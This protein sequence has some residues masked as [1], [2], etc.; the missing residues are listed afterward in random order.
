[1]SLIESSGP[2]NAAIPANCDGDGSK[3]NFLSFGMQK[4]D[5]KALIKRTQEKKPAAAIK[6]KNEYCNYP[7]KRLA[8]DAGGGPVKWYTRWNNET[9]KYIK[10]NNMPHAKHINNTSTNNF[11]L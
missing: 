7:G 1:M 10:V 9:K 4:I 5:P 2:S 3:G 11:Y 6:A 8:L